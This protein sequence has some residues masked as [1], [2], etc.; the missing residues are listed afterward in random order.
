MSWIRKHPVAALFLASLLLRAGLAVV[1]EFDP[2]MPEYYFTDARYADDM[3]SEILAARQGGRRFVPPV[4]PAKRLQAY[5]LALL[6]AAVGFRPLA[7]K[8]ANALMGAL[9]VLAF[10]GLARSAFGSRCALLA[11]ALVAAWPSH[12]FMT[13]QNFKDGPVMA[14]AFAGLWAFASALRS[15]AWPAFGASALAGVTALILAG[16]Q[17]ASLMAAAAGAVAAAA[18]FAWARALRRR[19]PSLKPF[20]CMLAAACVPFLYRPASRAVFEGPLKMTPPAAGSSQTLTAEVGTPSTAP[21]PWGPKRLSELR[22]REQISDQAWAQI[23]KGRRI[24]TQLFYGLEFDTWWDVL[25]FLPKGAFYVLFMPLPGLY[26]LEGNPGRIM[27]SLEN[28]VVLLLALFGAMAAARGP[29][30]PER[31]LLLAFFCVMA[32]GSALLELDL[33]GATRHRLVYLPMLLPFALSFIG[34]RRS[35]GP[36]KRK[37]FEVLECGGPGGTG[38]QVAAICN[39]LDPSR[40]DVSLVYAVRTGPPQGYRD[41]AKGAQAA[42]LI[43]EMTREISP[44]RDLRALLRLRRLFAVELPDVV[45]A[46]SSKAGVLARAAA[47]MTGVPLVFYSPRG[48][49]FL[50]SDKG[51]ASRLLYWLLEWSVSWIGDIVAVSPSEAA[52]A[53]PLAWGGP[54][55]VVCD[56]FLGAVREPPAER[57]GKGTLVAAPWAGAQAGIVIAACGRFTHARNPQAFLRLARDLGRDRPDTRF[58]WVG[59]GED[60]RAVRREADALGLAGKLEITG[61]LEPAQAL[62]RLASAGVFVHYS[63]WE[64]LPNAVL[65]AMALGLPV[66]ASDVPGNRD[67][68]LHGET[69]FIAKSEAELLDCCGRLAQ[70]PGLGR[71]LGLAGRE[72]VLKEFSPQATFSALERLYLAPASGV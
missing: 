72:R 31:L 18:A 19:E 47:W 42:F 2:I 34:E 46:H 54:V 70:D 23:Y 4:S 56:P 3:A 65:E 10:Y 60:E 68:V 50:Q 11:A 8:L 61:W 7:A 64:G 26:P 28:V 48:Y 35:P 29:K 33:G 9:S 41:K 32:A 15:A 39:G 14:A 44:L 69:G 63:R 66:V 36:R 53:R 24:G 37:V 5:A 16:F 40:F 38:N 25:A 49:G 45:H 6:Y 57:G 13:S 30:T 71:R 21:P 62:E 58:L 22:R 43:P 67:A 1:T 55:H 12:V 17:R 52:L 20:V 51:P 59:G 27:A